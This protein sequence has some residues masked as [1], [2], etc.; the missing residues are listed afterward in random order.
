MSR[1]EPCQT[2]LDRV[3]T[4][5][6]RNA[7]EFSAKRGG[8]LNAC[9]PTTT[10]FTDCKLLLSCCCVCVIE[11]FENRQHWTHTGTHTATS[12]EIS[13]RQSFQRRVALSP[14]LITHQTKP[15]V[16]ARCHP[17]PSLRQNNQD[18]ALNKRAVM[19]PVGEVFVCLSG[20]SQGIRFGDIS[21][22]CRLT[23]VRRR[24]RPISRFALSFSA[25][26]QQSQSPGSTLLVTNCM[27][28]PRGRCRDGAQLPLQGQAT[29]VT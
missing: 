18:G 12:I 22:Q 1:V 21:L 2:S 20:Y 10:H 6:R 13:T 3:S 26:H 29:V 7:F 24:G 15:A 8:R 11:R 23:A 5:V 25:D 9:L 14:S 17:D 16:T 19:S 28:I 4:G 27:P